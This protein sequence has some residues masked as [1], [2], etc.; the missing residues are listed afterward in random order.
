MQ[1]EMLHKAASYLASQCD[2]AIVRDGIGYNGTDTKFGHRI[3]AMDVTEWNEDIA[4]TAADVLRKYAEQLEYVGIDIKAIIGEET[5]DLDDHVTNGSIREISRDAHTQAWQAEH[6][7]KN[8]PYITIEGN[9]VK[10][11]NSYSIKDQLKPNGFVFGRNGTKTWDAPLNGTSAHTILGLGEIVLSDEQT[12]Q[13]QAFPAEEYV[14]P[15]KPENKVNITREDDHLILDTEW[16]VVPLSVTKAIPGRRWDGARKINHISASPYIYLLADEYNLTISDEARELIENTRE[17]YD[18]AQKEKEALTAESRATDTDM[19]VALSEYLR[20][21][22]Q[23]GAAYAIKHGSSINGDD[24]G[25]GKTRQALAAIETKQAFPALI[26]CP[27][28]L[29]SV[30]RDEIKAIMPHRRAYVYQGRNPGASMPEADIHIIGYTVVASYIPYL[31]K[32]A[33]LVCDESHY[34][35]NAKA[36]RAGAVMR[37]T[38][39]AAEKDKYGNIIPIPGNMGPDPL[40]ILLSGTPAVNRPRELVQ[41]LIAIDALSTTPKAVNGAGWFLWRYCLKLDEFGKPVQFRGHYNYNGAQNTEELHNWLRT[42]MVARTKDQVLPELPPKIR[43]PQFITLS[44]ESM[45]TY[46]RLKQQGAEKAAESSAEALVYLNSL[47]AAI[48]TAITQDGIDWAN[49]FLECGKSLIIFATHVDTQ[50]GLIEGLREAGHKVGHLLGGESTDA[51]DE[52]K[53]AF[54]AKETNVIVLSFDAHREGHTLTAASDVLFVESGWN[55]AT[56]DQAEDRAHRFGQANSV[57]AWYLI[58]QDTI[59]EWMY[60]LVEEKRKITDMVNKG[61]KA[62]DQ[63]EGIIAEL[64]SRLGVKPA[65]K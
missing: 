3:A 48:G 57:T 40:V 26:I 43:A 44:P 14:T 61:I 65:W 8:A 24:P 52:A 19:Q 56:Q 38:G 16:G 31:P 49:D 15:V 42:H 6:A 28:K 63:E 51:I 18:K 23:A 13:L 62:E 29:T 20:N 32:L 17:S 33:G 47:R 46:D 35:K 25:L 53:R 59:A 2:G 9:L 7:R 1:Y 11:W 36:D 34:I 21:Y 12:A 5:P 64:L 60:E 30:W 41:Q 50:K 22:Q 4:L 45:R 58:A 10:V 27:P 54:Q 37:I 55:A 39:H